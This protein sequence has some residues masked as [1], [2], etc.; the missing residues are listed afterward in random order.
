MRAFMLADLTEMLTAEPDLNIQHL[1]GAG[2]ERVFSLNQYEIRMIV[3]R[4]FIEARVT[5]DATFEWSLRVTLDDGTA[6]ADEFLVQQVV[7]LLRA[8]P[9]IECT[10]AA[11]YLAS[12]FHSEGCALA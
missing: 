6:G 12:A 5:D 7:N 4:S 1:G 3:R 8:L 11:S 2:E 10:C 9:Q